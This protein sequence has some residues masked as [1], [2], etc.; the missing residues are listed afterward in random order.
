MQPST[1]NE[2]IICS[3]APELLEEIANWLSSNTVYRLE[4]QRNHL[5]WEQ[6]GVSLIKRL[7]HA[8]GFTTNPT[9]LVI[10]V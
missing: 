4:H 3:P 1:S 7:L 8:L 10:S 2:E 6:K 5:A 9:T